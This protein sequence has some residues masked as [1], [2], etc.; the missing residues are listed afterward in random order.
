MGNT[1]CKGCQERH[2]GCHGTC[3]DY[4]AFKAEREKEL[5][6]IRKKKADIAVLSA[7]VREAKKRVQ[8]RSHT[9]RS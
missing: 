6:E 1:K 8:K 3:P 4:I 5:E 7:Y 9:K 2:V